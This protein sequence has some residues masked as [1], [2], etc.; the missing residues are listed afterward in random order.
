MVT[1]TVTQGTLESQKTGM[2]VVFTYEDAASAE[3]KQAE[4]VLK[5]ELAE[6]RKSKEFEGKKLQTAMLRTPSQ[7]FAKLLLVGL[8][9]KREADLET[10]RRAAGT[11]VKVAREFSGEL[12]VPFRAAVAKGFAEAAQALAEGILLGNYR[13]LR[14]KTQGLDEIKTL[15]RFTFLVEKQVMVKPARSGVERATVLA[16]A[17]NYARDLVNTPAADMSPADLEAEARKLAK[18]HGLTLT[19]FQEAEL[20]RR[21][22]G[23]I[24]AVGKSSA[25]RPRMIILEYKRP[26]AKKHLVF[27]GKGVCYDSGGYNLKPRMLEWMKDDMGGAA[28][29]LGM[30]DA[31][32]SLKVKAR[33]TVVIGAVENLI[34]GE[35]YKTGDVVRAMNGKTIEVAN[36]DAEGRI[37]LADC[38]SYASTLKP[39]TLIDIATLTGAAMSALGPNAAAVCAPDDRLAA[40]I[41]E[42]GDASG[43]RAWRIP[44]WDDYKEDIKS[45]IADV[46]NLGFS[47][48]AGITAGAVFLQEFVASPERWAHID[49]GCAVQEERERPYLPK[50]ATGWGVRALTRFVEQ[51]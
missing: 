9:K 50:G 11:A 31:I 5:D 24:V 32:A 18:R 51:G 20:K 15:K 4:S 49:I 14:Y 45:E 28:A 34:S 48:Y 35:A 10:L 27:C 1:G 46:K 29:L 19:V 23:A 6:L 26:G 7:P 41:I 37:V 33:V 12:A 47:F 36:T 22:M 30:L 43:D 44:M 25:V 39:D 21:K 2:L 17:V 40:E 3:Y 42:A 8:G 38:L 16:D 13:F